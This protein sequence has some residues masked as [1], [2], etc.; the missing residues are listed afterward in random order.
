VVEDEQALRR[1]GGRPLAGRQRGHAG[2]V[3][4]GAPSGARQNISA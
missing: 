4:W 1:P 2:T 3:P